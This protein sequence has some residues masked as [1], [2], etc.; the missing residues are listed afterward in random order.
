MKKQIVKPTP[1]HQVSKQKNNPII[2]DSLNGKKG[3]YILIGLLSAL[4]LFVFRDFILLNKVFLYKDIGS[5][6]INIGLPQLFHIADYIQNIGGIPQWSFYQGMGQNYLGYLSGDPFDMLLYFTTPANIVYMLGFV[7]ILKL[8]TAGIFFYL[9]L[10]EIKLTSFTA[11]IGAMCFAFCGFFVLG[12]GWRIFSSE[13]YQ[14][15]FLLFSIE[16]LLNKKWYYFPFAIALISVTVTFNLF[17]YSIVTAVYIFVRLYNQQAS[18]KTIM[19][20]YGKIIGL[21][22]LGVGMGAFIIFNKT[23]LILDSPRVSGSS[24]YFSELMSA[25]I[26]QTDTLLENLTKIGRLFSSDMLGSGVY[27][28]TASETIN[29]LEAPLFYVG[30]LSLLLFTQFFPSLSKQKKWVFGLIFLCA[31]LP[32]IFPFFRYTLWLFSGKY[33]R[34]L[35]FLF[36]LVLLIYTMLSLNH[37]DTTRKLN[38]KVLFGTLGFMLILLFMPDFVGKKGLFQ[39]NLQTFCLV[40]LLLYSFLISLF[41]VRSLA[42]Y[43]KFVLIVL[44]FIELAFMAN[45]TVNQ[46]TYPDEASITKDAVVSYMET[47]S[48]NGYNDYSIDAVRYI[49]SID[50]SFY[51]IEKTYNSGPAM[52]G[53]LND[54]LMQRYYGTSSYSSFNQ[55]NYVKFLLATTIPG[56]SNEWATRWLNGLRVDHPLLQIFANVHYNLSKM[57]FPAQSFS[58]FLNDSIAK[59]GDVYIYKTKFSLPLGY[60]YSNYMLRSTFNNLPFKDN[61][62]LEAVVIDDNMEMNYAH[63]LNKLEQPIAPEQYTIAELS[64]DVEKLSLE[65]LRLTRFG[66]NNIE[67]EITLSS[68]KLLFFTIPFDKNWKIFD[69]GKE[70]SLELVNIGFSG[71]LLDAGTHTIALRFEPAGYYPSIIIS[72]LSLLVTLLLIGWFCWGRQKFCPTNNVLLMTKKSR[73]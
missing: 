51:R 18:G 5:D 12:C 71:I 41:P 63:T 64:N 59:M 29:Y 70:R 1:K 16:K 56:D 6:S 43:V 67:G 57:P 10:R 21:G 7:E 66:Q 37:L 3:F 20:T 19:L 61:A 55:S 24:S 73:I 53:S 14:A 8:L 38:Y 49:N 22:I 2:P 62:F 45:I 40:F 32:F 35:S 42:R 39:S 72:W 9:F 17:V 28:T 60:T 27:F 33:Y 25:G 69:N 48:K 11:I 36:G 68:N 46:R 50:S 23:L 44:V 31:L 15:A 65:T 47:K 13:L 30:L 52:H 34:G 54:P 58:T 26:F 4:A